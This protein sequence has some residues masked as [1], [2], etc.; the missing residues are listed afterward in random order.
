MNRPFVCAI[1]LASGRGERLGSTL[2]KQFVKLAGKTMVEYSLE[3]FAKH[4]GIDQIVLV[5]HPDH[6]GRMETILGERACAK[7]CRLIAGG[8][9]RQQSST[10]GVAAAGDVASQVLIHDAARPLLSADLVSACLVSLNRYA[11][12]SAAVPAIDT[13]VQ[14]DGQGN[15]TAIPP[16]SSMW[17]LQTPQG[18][19]REI[20]R[21]AQEQAIA[22]GVSDVSD[23]CGLVFRYH[24]AEI[25]IVPGEE[26]N[27]KITTADDLSRA[28]QLLS[29][30]A[31]AKPPEAVG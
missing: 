13:M 4:P 15:L 6:R 22:D 1:I 29:T 16:R 14:A 10:L 19:R 23:D 17:R 8:A 27:F 9:T 5:V 26:R 24:L 7:P 25:G 31:W 11:A 12:I 20:I 3:R 30:S 18:F 21:E 28:E 2:P